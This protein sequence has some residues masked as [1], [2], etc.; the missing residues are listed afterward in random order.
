MTALANKSQSSVE[1]INSVIFRKVDPYTDFQITKRS[2]KSKRSISSPFPDLQ[3]IQSFILEDLGADKVHWSA[4]AYTPGRSVITCAEPHLGMK[5]GLKLDL[6]DFFSHVTSVRVE[7]ALN[8]HLEPDLAWMYSKLVT[9]DSTAVRDRLP[10]KYSRR[11][12]RALTKPSAQEHRAPKWPYWKPFEALTR[13]TLMVLSRPQRKLGFLPQGAPTSGMVANIAFA[14]IDYK[15]TSLAN[16]YELTYTRY[17]DDILFSSKI[18]NFS[19]ARALAVLNE[20]S[21]IIFEGGFTLNRAKTRMLTPGSRM[22]FLGLLVDGEQLRL[23]RERREAITGALRDVVKFS[24][25]DQEKR[26]L[27][28]QPMRLARRPEKKESRA[29]SYFAILNGYGSW[30]YGVDKALLEKL[31]NEFV[32]KSNAQALYLDPED[33]QLVATVLKVWNPEFRNAIR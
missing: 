11:V 28:G 14:G 9:R 17:S 10:A 6:E 31:R 18:P 3:R 27:S 22:Q 2:S 24:F 12:R 7:S 13:D 8:H 23:P 5:W 33:W 15:L 1:F 20:A 30:L 29:E 26:F 4:H 16:R 32:F 25:A 19:R 21:Q